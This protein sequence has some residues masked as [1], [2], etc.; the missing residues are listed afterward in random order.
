MLLNI[1]FETFFVKFD[2]TELAKNAVH[3]KSW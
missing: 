2:L 3:L 1:S